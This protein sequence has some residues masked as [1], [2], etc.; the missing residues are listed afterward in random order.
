[1]ENLT[2]PGSQVSGVQLGDP[3]YAVG[4]QNDAAVFTEFDAQVF[5]QLELDGAVGRFFMAGAT[6]KF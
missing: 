4:S 2:A 6:Y 1:V 3:Y 5:N